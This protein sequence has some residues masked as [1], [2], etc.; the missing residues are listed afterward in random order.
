MKIRENSSYKITLV[1]ILLLLPV[2]SMGAE[3]EFYSEDDKLAIVEFVRKGFLSYV[4]EYPGHGVGGDERVKYMI[5]TFGKPIKIEKLKKE[6]WREPGLIRD[7]II[8]YF[9]GVTIETSSEVTY[10]NQQQ[11]IEYIRV[12]TLEN[13]KYKVYKGIHIGMS[14]SEFAERLNLKGKKIRN[15]SII[16]YVGMHSGS[17]KTTI[18]V[19]SKGTINKIIWDY[20]E[21]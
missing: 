21:G 19:S 7:H 2:V 14:Y 13:P 5:E 17:L 12:I 6:D 18:F 9:N 15:D 16:Y 11:F 20:L 10:R 4:G 1:A 8:R 3:E